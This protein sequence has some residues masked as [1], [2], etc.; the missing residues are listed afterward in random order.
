MLG[1]YYIQW[2]S[3][4]TFHHDGQKRFSSV[5]G[6]MEGEAA[7]ARRLLS[8]NHCGGEG[9]RCGKA[10]IKAVAVGVDRKRKVHG[11]VL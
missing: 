3:P 7:R 11:E 5:V 1:L 9:K 4:E 8:I 10:C 2:R 6:A